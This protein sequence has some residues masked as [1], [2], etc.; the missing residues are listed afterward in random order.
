[1]ED[2]ILQSIRD[3]R[4]VIIEIVEIVETVKA[5]EAAKIDNLANKG[6]VYCRLVVDSECAPEQSCIDVGKVICRGNIVGKYCWISIVLGKGFVE[7]VVILR[8]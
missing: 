6:Q 1:M 8:K 2:I 3:F 5:V 7:E 4:Q